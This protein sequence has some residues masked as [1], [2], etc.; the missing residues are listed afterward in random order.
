[1]MYRKREECMKLLRFKLSVK[2]QLY[3][4]YLFGK[5]YFM[6]I[7][8]GEDV[9]RE[10]IIREMIVATGNRLSLKIWFLLK[11]YSKVPFSVKTTEDEEN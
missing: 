2:D 6:K 8:H 9:L 7:E 5:V 3:D 10:D 11:Q 4:D 1:M